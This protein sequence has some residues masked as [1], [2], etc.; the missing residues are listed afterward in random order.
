MSIKYSGSRG[1]FSSYGGLGLLSELVSSSGLSRRL[2][3]YLPVGKRGYKV[4]SNLKFKTLL[5]AFGIGGDCLEDLDVF[6]QDAGFQAVCKGRVY[7]SMCYGNFLRSFESWQIRGLNKVLRDLA[8]E[9]RHRAFPE[10]RDFVLDVDSTFHEQSGRKMEG[11]GYDYEKKWGLSSLQAFDQHGFQYAMRVREGSTFTSVGTAEVIR[12]VFSHM[13]RKYHRYMRGDSGMCNFDVMSAC[14][15]NDVD[16]VLA[17]RA[18]MYRKIKNSQAFW[19]WKK[20]GIKTR[21]GRECEIT[22]APYHPKGFKKAMRVV[23]IRAKK[24]TPEIF[25]KYDHYGWVTNIG[26]SEKS[27][28]EIIEFYRKRGNAENFIKELKNGYDIH[29]FPCQKLS[30]NKVYGIISAVA[31]NFM[32]VLGRIMHPKGLIYSKKIRFNMIFIGAQVVKK[33]RYTFMKVSK[34]KLKEVAYWLSKI[35]QKVSYA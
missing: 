24:K 25:D 7:S 18:N 27:D 20:S 4:H 13:P 1:D 21:D 15:E 6:S 22:C 3:E 17:M 14:V 29:H 16:Y 32:R 28:E 12:Q 35:K 9:L 31:M 30:A 10:D 23:M 19:Y 5:Y 33:S 34:H 8:F 2:K 26:T 11:L